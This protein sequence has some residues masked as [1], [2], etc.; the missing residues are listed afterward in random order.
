MFHLLTA[1]LLAAMNPLPRYKQFLQSTTHSACEIPRR[2]SVHKSSAQKGLVLLCLGACTCQQ[3]EALELGEEKVDFQKSIAPILAENCNHCHGVDENTRYGGLRLDVREGAIGEL[4]SGLH[5]IVPGD[6]DASELLRRVTS[7]DDGEV[8]PPISEN[9]RLSDSQ[10][11]LL[12]RW[13]E[14]GATYERHWGFVPPQKVSPLETGVDRATVE[15]SEPNQKGAPNQK[16]D[17]KRS[18]VDQFIDAKLASLNIPAASQADAATLVRRLYLDVIGLPPSPAELSEALTNGYEATVEKLLSSPRYGEKWGRLWLDLARYSDTN[19]YE[20]DMR[21]EQWKYRDWVIDAINGDMPYDQFVIEQIAG[22]LLPN[23]TQSQ[24]IATGFLRNS[25]INEEGAIVPEQFRLFELFDRMDCIGKSVLGI[26]AQCAQCHSHKFDPISHD[27]YFGMFAYL[28]NVYEAQSWVYTEDQLKQLKQIEQSLESIAKTVSDRTPGW[29]ESVSKWASEVHATDS[30]WNVLSFHQRESVSGLNHPTQEPDGR[31]L[32]KGHVSN[33]VFFVGKPFDG[34]EGRV[35]SVRLEVLQHGDLPFNGP[36][37]S[38]NG[39]WGIT[40]FELW[41]KHSGD[42][43][44]S[45]VPLAKVTADFSNAEV[46]AGDQ[47]KKSGPVSFLLD[48][49][50]DTAWTA[51]RG[52]GRRNQASVAIINL[53]SS[54][55]L[56]AD[57]ELKFVMHMTDMVG[58]CRLSVAE[59]IDLATDE[60]PYEVQLVLKKPRE[61]W[62]SADRNLVL[63]AWARRVPELK[64]LVDQEETVWAS[65]PQA[66]TSILHLRERDEANTRKTYLLDRGEWNLPKHEVQPHVPKELN[67]LPDDQ[68]NNRLAFAKWLVSRDSPVAARVAVNRVWQAIFGLGLNE[69]ADDFGTRSPHP[70]YRELL[71]WLAV[72]FMENQWSHKHLLRLIL[73]SDAYKRSSVVSGGIRELDPKNQWLARGPRFRADAEV[74]RDIALS[75]SGLIHH[76]LGGASVIPPV[77]QNVLDYNYVYPEYWKPAEGPERYRRTVYGFRKRSMP[78]PVTSSFDA[79]NGDFA[80]AMRV[81]SN[82]PLAALAGMNET[83]FVEAARALGLRILREGGSTDDER[84]QY[85]FTLCLSRQANPAEIQ[86]VKQLLQSQRARVSEGWLNPRELTTGKADALPDLPEGANPQDAA[87]W[88]LVSRVLI[89]LDETISKN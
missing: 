31:I 43:D 67:A 4:D 78:D 84:I 75:V 47:K 19:G 73:K 48:S 65:F 53:E 25:M 87:V 66:E 49:N 81:R 76:K 83:I 58:C 23:A 33:D 32:M 5:A 11:E 42:K 68:P 18:I 39:T 69:T 16:S 38:S 74:V 57:S 2:P 27:E 24:I 7:M 28:N 88:M 44:F 56:K 52:V 59:Q 6:P 36:G 63:R 46:V 1:T 61:Q 21:R 71:D 13:I 30:K 80:C 85:A 86:I 40:N 35:G 14:Q 72:D 79:P 8:M 60:T 54:L 3:V 34:G 62:S 10:K 64:D 82:T 29:D 20:K 50:G 17:A 89:N 37:R 70:E 77:P 41:V 51:D 45:R 9:K 12:R 26:T 55:E 22:D 15:P